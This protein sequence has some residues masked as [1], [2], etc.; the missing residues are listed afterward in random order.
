MKLPP[1][2]LWSADEPRAVLLEPLVLVNSASLP[3]AVLA[4]PVVLLKSANAPAAVLAAPGGI[5]K[6]CYDSRGCVRVAGVCEE[7]S[8]AKCRIGAA[9]GIALKRQ[10]TNFRFESACGETEKGLLSF[11]CV[12][13]RIATVRR[14]T[15]SVDDWRK[16]GVGEHEDRQ[17]WI[18]NSRYSFHMIW[19]RFHHFLFGNGLLIVFNCNP[20]PRGIRNRPRGV[21]FEQRP[22]FG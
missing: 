15:D 9:A 19:F 10:E 20:V 18:N 2:L 5:A 14:R 13:V 6:E 16:P 12:A 22:H 21:A 17:R 11:R 4:A 7:C 3:I 1:L 8:S